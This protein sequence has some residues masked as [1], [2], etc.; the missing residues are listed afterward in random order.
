MV[1]DLHHWERAIKEEGFPQMEKSPHWWEVS[2]DT[3]G[4]LQPQR[5][6]QQQVC[7]GQSRETDLHRQLVLTGT[8]QPEKLVCWGGQ[9]LCADTQALE[10]R[11]WGED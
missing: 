5:R 2:Q 1:Q 3:G 6:A 8:P 7:R 10:V 4:A 11:P 9:G